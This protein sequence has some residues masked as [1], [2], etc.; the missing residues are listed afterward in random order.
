MFVGAVRL[1]AVIHR[2]GAQSTS[3]AHNHRKCDRWKTTGWK[4]SET[5]SV[6]W[7]SGFSQHFALYSLSHSEFR[8][9]IESNTGDSSGV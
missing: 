7:S 8:L 4:Q 1:T 5:H 3:P 6:V 9:N 2:D